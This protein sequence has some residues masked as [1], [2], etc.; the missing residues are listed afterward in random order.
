[1]FYSQNSGTPGHELDSRSLISDDG[2]FD[3]GDVSLAGF[4]GWID[5]LGATVDIAMVCLALGCVE[6]IVRP[7]LSYPVLPHG[8]RAA[9]TVVTVQ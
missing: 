8:Q 2:R 4:G 5:R 6:V 9:Q 7:V 3:D 1:M